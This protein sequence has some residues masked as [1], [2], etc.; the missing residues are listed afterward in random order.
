MIISKQLVRDRLFTKW[1]GQLKK[2]YKP[3]TKKEKK[4]KRK[5]YKE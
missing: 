2:S 1:L 3:D 4:E 5:K